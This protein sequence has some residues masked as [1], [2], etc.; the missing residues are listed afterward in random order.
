MQLLFCM[1]GL[2]LFIFRVKDTFET[3]VTIYQSTGRNTPNDL[4]LFSLLEFAHSNLRNVQTVSE[5]HSASNPAST[6]VLYRRRHDVDHSP[7]SNA[8]VKNEGAIPVLPLY[9]FTARTNNYPFLPFS[10]SF[11]NHISQT[12]FTSC[13]T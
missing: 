6:R 3:S 9:A 7:P 4:N 11:L 10:Y 5:A 2:R 12:G 13:I 8:G 1:L